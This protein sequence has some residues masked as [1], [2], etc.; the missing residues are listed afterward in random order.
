M[1]IDFQN[2]SCYIF[3]YQILPEN[4]LNIPLF[5]ANDVG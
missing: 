3:M 5:D 1:P 2:T 4:K